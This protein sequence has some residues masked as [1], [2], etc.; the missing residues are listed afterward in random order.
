MVRLNGE[1]G[2]SWALIDETLEST[3]AATLSQTNLCAD[4]ELTC[5]ERNQASTN[6][7]KAETVI[8]IPVTRR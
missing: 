2:L 3:A 4:I 6:R 8:G 5:T 7:T 1:A